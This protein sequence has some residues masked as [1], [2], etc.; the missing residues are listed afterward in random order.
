MIDH[1]APQEAP[2][3]RWAVAG[4]IERL[5]GMPKWRRHLVRAERAL[6]TAEQ[7]IP[8]IDDDPAA[9]IARLREAIGLAMRKVIA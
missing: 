4:R 8:K 2:A 3:V 1:E 5:A 6:L 7:D 9:A